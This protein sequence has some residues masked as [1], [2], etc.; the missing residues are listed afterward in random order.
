MMRSKLCN[1][2]AAVV[3]IGAGFAASAWAADSTGYPQKPI[4]II[5]H[6]PAGSPPDVVARVIGERLAP[7]LGQPVIVENRPGASGTIALAA[8]AKAQPD[9]Y[10]LGTMTLSH[11]VAPG[12]IAQL[13]YDTA[14]DLAPIE[15]TTQASILLVVR[16][17]APLRSLPDLIKAAKSQPGRLTYASAGNGTPL[18]LAVEVFKW[19]A[20]V[21][22][23]HVP[24]KGAL[25]AANALLGQQVDLLSTTPGAVLGGIRSGTLRAIAT[26]GSKRVPALPE[27]P[28][29][30][31]LGFTDF[32]VRDWQGLVAPSMT[33]K[34]LVEH[35][36]A[37]VNKVL[38]DPEVR[39]RFARVGVEPVT[40]SGPDAF[41]ALT[42]SELAR[43]G[44]IVRE[45]GIHAD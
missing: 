13:P 45:A 25:A 18:H 32:D 20:G 39:E 21:D 22:I 23:Q 29:L 43:W 3:V 24:Y 6:A 12:L 35:I 4:H 15:Q 8:V 37:D 36:A 2:A 34:P 38:H 28:T 30:S 19:R 40:D 44:K 17:D 27:V 26:T 41:G 11:A 31:E 9:G 42:R 10:T 1:T 16:A 7:A 5:T 14:R 33:P